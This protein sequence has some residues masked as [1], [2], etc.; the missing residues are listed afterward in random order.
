MTYRR[1]VGVARYDVWHNGT[2]DDPQS[3]NSMDSQSSIDDSC[4]I[5]CFAH[6]T[7]ASRMI[8]S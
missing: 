7:G 6:F 2:V 8:N 3:F 1:S 5:G 4:G